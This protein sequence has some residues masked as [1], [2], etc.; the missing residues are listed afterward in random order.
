MK[1]VLL[2]ILDGFGISNSNNNLIDNTSMPNYKNIKDKYPCASLNASGSAIGYYDNVRGCNTIGHMTIG[3]GRVIKRK[4]LQVEELFKED[5]LENNNNYQEMV[6]YVIDKDVPLHIMIMLSDGGIHSHIDVLLNM[7][8]KLHEKHIENLYFHIISDGIDTKKSI[9]EF[10]NILND[11]IR[12]F[13]MGSIASVCGRYYAMDR[14]SNYSRTKIYTDL[15]TLGKGKYCEN[16]NNVLNFYKNNEITDDKIPPLL[17]NRKGLIKD[18]HVL[19]CLNYRRDRI[20]QTLNALTNFKFNYYDTIKMD[21]LKTYT[22]Y[23]YPEAKKSKYFLD[24]LK[25]HNTISTYLSDLGMSQARIT[26]LETLADVTYFFDGGR[27]VKL[28]NCVNIYEKYTDDLDKNMPCVLITKDAIKCMEDDYDFILV[29]LSCADLASNTND[30]NKIKRTLEVMDICVGKLFDEAQ[31]NFYTLM[32]TSSHGN[33]EDMDVV[34]NTLN[35]VPFIICDD[36]VK[37]SNGELSNIAP[38]ILDYMD[39]RIPG[40]MES[41]SLLKK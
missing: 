40:E 23:N 30:I 11:K 34:G 37:L 10:V 3:A 5:V 21:N 6:N 16:L 29:N 38:T 1:K 41:D 24:D 4:L 8:E 35:K 31:D 25:I 7:M 39:I 22:I 33:L 13:K 26:R 14:D 17:V 12:L 15:V 19:L 2:T 18:G 36:K 9:I 28:D 32:I 20:A 27:D